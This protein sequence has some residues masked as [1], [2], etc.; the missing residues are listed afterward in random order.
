MTLTPE[1]NTT[2]ETPVPEGHVRL[3]ID[4]HVVDAP[5]GELLIRTCERI[6]IVIPRFCDHPLLDPA[7]ACRQCLVEVE[8]GG[9]PMPKPQA[10]CTMTVADGM[11]VKTQ[12]TSE[13]ADKAQQGVM[14]L[15]LINHPLDCPICD[16]GGECPLQNQAMAHGRADSRFVER[17]RTFPKPLPISSQVL[18]DRER[19]V[20]CQRCTRFSEEI[21]GDP[22]IDLLERGANQQ[23]G[24]AEDQPFQS[25]FSGNTIQICPVGALTSAAYRF[26]SRP[27]D[28]RSTPGTCEHCSS[29]CDMRTDSRRGTVLRR[30]AGNDPEVNEEW[31]CD[32]GRF[33]FRYLGSARRIT[34]PLVRR[35]DGELEEASWTEALQIA[36]DGLSAA[37]DGAGIGVL[38]G[39]RLT[40]E[41][42]YSY[43]KFARV[44][45]RTNDIDFRSRPH[46]GE[47]LEFLAAHVVG[48]A[49]EGVPGEAAVT[50]EKIENAPA[51]LTVATDPEEESGIVFLRLRKAWRKKGLRH[52]QVAPF[53]TTGA[54]KTGATVLHAVPGAEAA[55]VADPGADAT[56][57]LEQPGAVILV[58]DRAA[59]SPGLYSAVSALA[60]RTGASI[61]WLPRR[62]GDRGALEA[63][64]VPT[65]LP[66][67][68]P[69]TDAAARAELE[70]LWGSGPLPA[71]PGRD[72][73]AILAAAAAGELAA[74]V[75]GGVDPHD[76][77]DPQAAITALREVGFL[78]SLEIHTSAV[79][80]LADVVLPVAPD[81]Q[82]SGS[83]VN[84]EGRNRPFGVALDAT[85]VLPD[86]RVLDTLGVEMDT[87]L[88]TQTPAAAAGELARLGTRRAG[89]L[90]P[91]VAAG[92][93][94]RPGYGQA[95]L[96][97]SR[98]LV[99]D[100]SLAIDEP[101]LAGT[102]RRP[103][104]KLNAATAERLG[105]TE[106][107]DA[108]VR[109]DRGTITLPVALADTPDGVVWLPTCSPGSH[110]RPTLGAG[111]GDLVG[112]VPATGNGSAS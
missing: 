86:C 25:Y 10:S 99:D 32:K 95:V 112:V 58:G 75:V 110:V 64:A 76:M 84:W 100:A 88:F 2:E 12:N 31:L 66:G 72:G 79:T 59:E 34:R 109:T 23:I 85:G 77:A 37:R 102:A 73:D 40:V 4:G 42:A 11:V 63:G 50:F 41:D 107:E 9:R 91:S 8:M 94:R 106:G 21:A 36:A 57:A 46:S 54:E 33:A 44:A 16:K 96:A 30:L 92:E 104:V 97:T 49:P 17:K 5:K 89:T 52:F 48:T 103:Y 1:K 101:A 61:G 105:L 28:L 20:L 65:L 98:Q 68:R 78:V 13:R 111:H 24:I 39:G 74:L 45:A 108:A 93:P 19:C 90:A 55:V 56:A 35:A 47:E 26:R 71:E 67:G 29:G 51:V 6:G 80:E 27:F 22:F 70:R 14:E 87:D 60:A 62:A 81:A 18:L 43:A 7:G 3:T 83:Y 69:V 53:T 38:P 15:L 82:R